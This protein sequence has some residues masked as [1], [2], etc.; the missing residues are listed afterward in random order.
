MVA[1]IASPLNTSPNN[2]ISKKNHKQYNQLNT[3]YQMTSQ[4]DTTSQS[5]PQDDIKSI[6]PTEIHDK[7]E[8]KTK[9]GTISAK[10]TK[11]RVIHKTKKIKHVK[12]KPRE[13]KHWILEKTHLDDDKY[14]P[15]LVPFS[16]VKIM[17]EIINAFGD[18]KIRASEFTTVGVLHDKLLSY[19]KALNTISK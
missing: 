8:I 3:N 16:T 18:R 19:F 2:F 13:S 10:R 17:L 15:L 9:E 6:S 7:N 5:V 11:K 1:D 12:S 4:Q 14:R